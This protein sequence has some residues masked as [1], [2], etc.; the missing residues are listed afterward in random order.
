MTVIILRTIKLGP[1]TEFMQTVSVCTM[2][3]RVFANQNVMYVF[4]SDPSQELRPPLNLTWRTGKDMP[5]AMGGPVQSVVIGYSVYVGGGSPSLDKNRYIVMKLDLRR[6]EWTELPQYSACYFSMTSLANRLVLVGGIQTSQKLTNQIAVFESG[7]WTHPY[8]PMHIA[9]KCS[10]A[11][12]FNNFII[13]AGGSLDKILSNWSR[14]ESVEI[15]NLDLGR[16]Y[17]VESLP[18]PRTSGRSTR[19]GN[20]LFLMGGFDST[21]STKVVHKIDLN[22]LIATK[23]VPK[24]ATFPPWQ[25]IEDT[26]LGLSTPLNVDGSLFAIGGS[27][28]SIHY[29]SSSIYLYKP[30]SKMWVKVGD[31]PTARFGCSCSVLPDGEVIIAGGQTGN[32]K[33]INTVDFVSITSAQ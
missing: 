24:Q 4:Q 3:I 17:I 32:G 22:E 8:P 11:L 23:V 30:D 21:S 15:L 1:A 31:L 33:W 10:T 27:K 26:P 16:W 18:T 19:V 14:C 20:I 25:T 7:K 6:D 9:R 29:P 12:T 13:V 28:A 5:I 2:Q